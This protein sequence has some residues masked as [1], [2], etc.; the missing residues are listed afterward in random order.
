MN[1]TCA[2]IIKHYFELAEIERGRRALKAPR[3]FSLCINGPRSKSWHMC[4]PALLHCSLSDGCE[5]SSRKWLRLYR[6]QPV[7]CVKSK[8][9]DHGR[10]AKT[11]DA[12]SPDGSAKKSCAHWVFHRSRH[13]VYNSNLVQHSC[14]TE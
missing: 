10:R 9:G 1:A 5:A 8:W 12:Q 6:Q 4:L 11:D 14:L 13:M 7:F 2:D 3:N